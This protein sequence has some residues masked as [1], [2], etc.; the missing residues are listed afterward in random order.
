[1]PKSALLELLVAAVVAAR[2]L[3][4]A[5]AEDAVKTPTPRLTAAQVATLAAN[6]LKNR[7]LDVSLYNADKPYFLADFDIHEVYFFLKHLAH[8]TAAPWLL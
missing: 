5:S 4:N 6:V 3:T 2:P 1:M 8:R 7:G